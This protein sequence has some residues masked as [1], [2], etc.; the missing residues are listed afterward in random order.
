M[1]L[2]INSVE[3]QILFGQPFESVPARLAKTGERGLPSDLGW[4]RVVPKKCPS[5]AWPFQH[6]PQT[7]AACKQGACNRQ[8]TEFDNAVLVR[9]S[10]VWI[11]Y[12]YRALANGLAASGNVGSRSTLVLG[13]GWGSAD[14]ARAVYVC[15][16]IG[17]ATALVGD[18]GNGLAASGFVGASSTLVLSVGCGAVRVVSCVVSCVVCAV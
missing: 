6:T 4:L 15:G 3:A 7:Q 17:V 8:R 14:T 18:G 11:G 1:H 2:F 10:K 16:D 12:R 9:L 13:V 5:Y